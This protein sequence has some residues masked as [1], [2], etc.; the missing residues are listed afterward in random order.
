VTTAFS[1]ERYNIA[2]FRNA[3]SEIKSQI[4]EVELSVDDTG[5]STALSD[6]R[7]DID[8]TQPLIDKADLSSS[9]DVEMQMLMF[10]SGLEIKMT[11]FANDPK[12][13]EVG[14]LSDLRTKMTNFAQDLRRKL[15]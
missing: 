8:M 12:V 2:D 13:K 9:A 14:I 7:R 10:L 4:E 15:A 5:I 1:K 6:I 11:N 3:L